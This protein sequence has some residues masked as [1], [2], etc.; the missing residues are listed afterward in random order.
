MHRHNNLPKTKCIPTQNPPV[1]PAWVVSERAN[2]NRLKFRV[3]PIQNHDQSAVRVPRHRIVGKQT[4]THTMATPRPVPAQV[5]DEAS[6]AL[7]GGTAC[8]TAM[9]SYNYFWDPAGPPASTTHADACIPEVENCMA[10]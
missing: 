9:T 3:H 6:L 7:C 2:P 5:W 4:V 1:S 10:R 8:S